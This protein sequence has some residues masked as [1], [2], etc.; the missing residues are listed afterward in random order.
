[1]LIIF[2]TDG[3]VIESWETR[4]GLRKCPWCLRRRQDNIF[5]TDGWGTA[6]T[7]SIPGGKFQW[8]LGTPGVPRPPGVP[9]NRP[10]DLAIAPDGCLFVSDGYVNHKVHKFSPDGELIKSWGEPGRGP[11]I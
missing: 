3:N 10:T 4:S 7:S 5:L 9:F 1:M 8:T 2:D 11:D 6:S